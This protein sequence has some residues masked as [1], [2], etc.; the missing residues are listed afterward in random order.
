MLRPWKIEVCDFRCPQALGHHGVA[1]CQGCRPGTFLGRGSVM[2]EPIRNCWTSKGL[3]GLP[4]T[5]A[6]GLRLTEPTAYRAYSP[7]AYVAKQWSQ[8]SDL[9]SRPRPSLLRST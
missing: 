7:T 5:R 9:K 4:P 6:Y 2:P 3:P 1:H 8:E